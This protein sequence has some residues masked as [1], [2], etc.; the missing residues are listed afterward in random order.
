MGRSSRNR[1]TPLRS[2]D[3]FKE[4][5][6]RQRDFKA[7]GLREFQDESVIS[8]RLLHSEHR[9][10]CAA[11]S[12]IEPQPMQRKWNVARG[13]VGWER[14]WSGS[15]VAEEAGMELQTIS[16]LANTGRFY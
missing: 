8:S 6:S 12:V 16:G 13:T 7:V 2:R 3:S 5:R 9:K 15:D 11:V 14:W 10:S 4:R 1:H